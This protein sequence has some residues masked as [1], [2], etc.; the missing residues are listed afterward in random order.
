[1]SYY[2]ILWGALML[3]ALHFGLIAAFTQSL[4][5]AWLFGCLA[6]LVYLI[7][8]AI[9]APVFEDIRGLLFAIGGGA[10]LVVIAR[11]KV[12]KKFDRKDFRIGR[13][14]YWTPFVLEFVAAAVLTLVRHRENIKR[15][16]AGTESRFEKK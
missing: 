1:M 13:F 7:G 15:L 10:E 14:W 4:K 12:G 2:N 8:L 9:I 6:V 3:T 11:Y 16:L 5:C